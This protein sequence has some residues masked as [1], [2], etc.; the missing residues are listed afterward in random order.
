MHALA[1]TWVA[2]QTVAA[3]LVAL[4]VL[5]WVHLL[6]LRARGPGNPLPPAPLA[7]GHCPPLTVQLPLYN[8][9]PV[10]RGLLAS[11]AAL[12]WPRDRLQIQVLDDSTDETVG[13]VDD[14]VARLA[15]LGLPI[16]VLRRADRVGF[17]AGALAAAMPAVTGELVAM[18]D[19]DFRPAPDFLLRAAG[20]LGPDV[21]LV[22][23]RWSFTNAG[24]SALTRAQALHLDAHFA[25][26]QQARSDGGLLMGFNGT[27][28]VWRRACIDAG[29]G[30]HTDTLTEDLD[31]AY[32]AQLAGWRLRYVDALHVPSELPETL[33]SIRSQQHRWL[34]GGAQ[35]GRKLLGPIWRSDQP[36]RRKLQGTAH[37]LASSVFL[38]VLL[39][40]GGMPLQP[41][42]RAHGPA[43]LPAAL[44]PAGWL[45][46]GVL[47]VLIVAYGVVCTHR[48]GGLGPGLLRLVR[49]LPRFLALVTALA[50]HGARAAWLGWTAPTG[51]F[52][53]T[54]RRGHGPVASRRPE[55]LW[56]EA[57][58]TAWSGVGTAMAADQG[59]WLLMVFM[60]VQT[61]A[62][63][64]FTG[65]SLGGGRAAPAVHEPA[66]SRR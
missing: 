9:A 46:Q 30:W 52:V 21:G 31:L 60:G 22:Q 18:F 41:W 1:A 47:G 55:T 7:H 40:I 58:L 53:R 13:L 11:V 8:E 43:W 12:D 14:E 2:L 64:G 28:G 27:A 33:P 34:R 5:A 37:L 4:H 29:G 15:A 66:A 44:A 59:L 20:A 54:P 63:A 19:A 10:V 17:K 38:P 45:L 24:H 16:S 50:P 35:V 39:I 23:A 26:E 3:A 32:R 48:Q 6:W 36:L 65:L 56:L 61:G 49:D 57:V 62:L 51:D 25:L 42:L